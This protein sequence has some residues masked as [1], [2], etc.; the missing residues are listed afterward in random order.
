MNRLKITGT[1]TSVFRNKVWFVISLVIMPNSSTNWHH[2]MMHEHKGGTWPDVVCHSED[3]WAW[4]AGQR[5]LFKSRCSKCVSKWPTSI[6]ITLAMSETMCSVHGGAIWPPRWASD[7][8]FSWA[9]EWTVYRILLKCRIWPAGWHAGTGKRPIL[10]VQ[11]LSGGNQ[12]C[13]IDN[14]VWAILGLISGH[15]LRATFSRHAATSADIWGC[16]LA[17]ERPHGL[18]CLFQSRD[19]C[20]CRLYN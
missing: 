15:Q 6:Q 19:T 16:K 3:Q 4:T 2:I 9:D 1:S 8:G 13:A 5:V 12:P 10:G 18:S 17:M 20:S 14:R 7:S 11:Q